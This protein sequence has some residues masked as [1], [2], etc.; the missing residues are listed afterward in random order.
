VCSIASLRPEPVLPPDAPTT[1]FFSYCR[2]D[3]EFAIRLAEDLKA[4][5]ASVWMDQ[6]DIEPGMPWDRAVENAVTSCPRMLVI[7]SP[8]SVSS[9]NVRDEVSFALSKQKRVIPVLYRECDIPFRLARL[10]HIDF[11]TDYAR[12]LKTLLKTLGAEQ[13]AVAAE[14]P[15]SQVLDALSPHGLVMGVGG[16]PSSPALEGITRACDLCPCGSEAR[17]RIRI[18][19]GEGCRVFAGA[20]SVQ[21]L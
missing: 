21:V 18:L 1:A 20:L 15:Q 19:R 8:V 3:S 16:A 6:L 14:G 2:E 4:G 17:Q 7:L 12:G 10:Q 13:Q 9:D 11:R 5:G